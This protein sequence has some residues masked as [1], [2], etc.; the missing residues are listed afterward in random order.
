MK[1]VDAVGNKAGFQ[2]D[3]EKGSRELSPASLLPLLPVT[4]STPGGAQWSKNLGHRPCSLNSQGQREGRRDR[5]R[6]KY[7]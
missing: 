3:G 7:L 6:I 2:Q 5:D 4:W 1:A